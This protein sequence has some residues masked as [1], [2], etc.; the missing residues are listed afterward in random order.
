MFEKLTPNICIFHNGVPITLLYR[1]TASPQGENWKVRPAFVEEPD[2]DELFK[3]GDRVTFV[4]TRR[5]S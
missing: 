5:L 3:Q 4:H 1:I 2:R